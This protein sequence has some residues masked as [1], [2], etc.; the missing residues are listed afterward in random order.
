M[1]ENMRP[2]A[3]SKTLKGKGPKPKHPRNSNAKLKRGHR[4]KHMTK[5]LRR[6]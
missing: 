5:R 2:K 1:M 3:M 4:I 6:A